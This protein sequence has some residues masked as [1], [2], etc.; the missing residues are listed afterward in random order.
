MFLNFEDGWPKSNEKL[1]FGKNL[2]V[3][4]CYLLLILFASWQLIGDWS[5]SMVARSTKYCVVQIMRC[6]CTVNS[7]GNS[8]SVFTSLN[9]VF[10]YFI[11]HY[12]FR[13][14]S[15]CEWIDAV[16][17]GLYITFTF[18]MTMQQRWRRKKR[19]YKTIIL[20]DHNGLTCCLPTAYRCS[21]SIC[22]THGY[23]SD[24]SCI[25]ETITITNKID[26]GCDHR[27]HLFNFS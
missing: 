27:S 18:T 9:R 13:F 10:F 8:S 15:V 17:G 19:R 24:M 2:F 14:V 20:F 3:V 7:N 12:F 1:W 11:L 26:S 22:A 6:V 16:F 21:R 4:Y 25:D 23:T 5:H